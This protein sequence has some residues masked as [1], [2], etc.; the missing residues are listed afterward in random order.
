MALKKSMEDA[1]TVER[2]WIVKERDRG[3]LSLSYDATKEEFLGIRI[4]SNIRFKQADLLVA[5]EIYN[6]YETGIITKVTETDQR[7]VV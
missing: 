1:E 3:K 2:L 7:V 4:L 6:Q 5:E